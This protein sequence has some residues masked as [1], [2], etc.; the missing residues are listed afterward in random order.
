MR[1]SEFPSTAPKLGSLRLPLPRSVAFRLL[2]L[3]ALQFVLGMVTNLYV[4]VPTHTGSGA[5]E[6]FSGVVSGVVWASVQGAWVLRLHTLLGLL[7]ILVAGLQ[8][9]SAIARRQRAWIVISIIAV[10]FIIGAGFNGASFL[11]YGHD[12]SSLFMSLGFAIA[13]VALVVGLY[14]PLVER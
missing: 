2:L 11:N 4:S 3:L 14:L 1:H 7:L 8:V 5:S 9:A 10:L 12:F 13:L 6:Y